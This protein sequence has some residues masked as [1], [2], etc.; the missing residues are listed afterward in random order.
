MLANTELGDITS[1]FGNDPRHLVAEYS[2]GW[3]NV[4][5]CEQDVSM[6]E[7]GCLYIDQ[8]LA[9]YWSGDVD[10]FDKIEPAPDRVDDKG[11]HRC[12]PC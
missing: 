4:V 1:D 11:F 8:H 7:P 10:V 6:A 12:Q 3:E 9:S 5:R 2:R